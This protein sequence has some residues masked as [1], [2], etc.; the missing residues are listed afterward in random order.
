[1]RLVGWGGTWGRNQLSPKVSSVVAV[2]AGFGLVSVVVR[3]SAIDDD[4]PGVA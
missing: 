4:G 3:G 1:M 2:I